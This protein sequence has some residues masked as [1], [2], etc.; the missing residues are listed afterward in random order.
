MLKQEQVGQT[1]E[2]APHSKHW[3]PMYSQTSLPM[4]PVVIRF[5]TREIQALFSVASASNRAIEASTIFFLRAAASGPASFK[6]SRRAR[7][8][9]LSLPVSKR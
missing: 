2:Q 1:N 8:S 5:M 3:S 6:P 9:P 7:A 4:K